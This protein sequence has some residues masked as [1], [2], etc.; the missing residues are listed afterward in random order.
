MVGP[1]EQSETF[2]RIVTRR[3]DLPLSPSERFPGVT[4]R[5]YRTLPSVLQDD[6]ASLEL[7]PSQPAIYD[8]PIGLRL[9]YQDP[10]S[11]AEHYLIRYPPNL[12]TQRHRHTSAHTIIVLDGAMEANGQLLH[13]GSYGH[14]EAGTIH[15]H[16]PAEGQPCLFVIIFHGPFDVTA[17]EA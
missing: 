12:R 5:L 15:H 16:A 2:R 11:G 17:A 8:R 9:L 1:R 7:E 13:A 10:R 3:R 14:F 4:H 6:L